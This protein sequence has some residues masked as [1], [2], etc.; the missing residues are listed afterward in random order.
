M[1]APYARRRIDLTIS[2]G[3][4]DFGGSGTN[5]VKLRGMRCFVNAETTANAPVVAIIRV[6]GMTKD[7]I[8]QVTNA[9]LIWR[10]RDNT[11]L[12]EAGDDISG[13][14]PV[15][16]GDIYE[17]YPDFSSQ[18]DVAFVISGNNGRPLQIDPVKPSSFEGAVS[19]ATILQRMAEKAGLKLEISD[20]NA[21]FDNP[22]FPRTLWDQIAAVA[23]AGNYFFHVDTILNILAVWAKDGG[24]SSGGQ[25]VIG[26]ETGMIGYPE[27]QQNQIKV[28]TLFNPDIKIGQTVQVKSQ[29]VGAAGKWYLVEVQQNLSSETFNGPWETVAV[30]LPVDA[31][32]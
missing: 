18:P 5:V 12:V 23:K 3:K 17:A 2:L 20:V 10:Q 6:S 24:R 14:S 26:P 22:Y 31:P 29:L 13:V 28:R 9:G 1:T 11:V 30:G 19:A 7:Q 25:V 8:D 15:F 4:G 32:R 21:V 27:F 16:K